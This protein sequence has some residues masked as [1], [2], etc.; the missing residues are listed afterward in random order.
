MGK[1]FYPGFVVLAGVGEYPES[2]G[3]ITKVRME[4]DRS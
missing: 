2:L 3:T 4:P 1:P